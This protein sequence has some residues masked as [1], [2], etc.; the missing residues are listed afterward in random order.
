[1]AGVV[2]AGCNLVDQ[3]RAIGHEKHLDSKNPDETDFLCNAPGK[4]L[5]G[6][7]SRAV[8][9]RGNHRHIQDVII[10]EVFANRKGFRLPVCPASYNNRNFL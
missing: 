5:R 8:N 10:V 3:D 1:M 9:P 6:I 7:G 4:V 2:R